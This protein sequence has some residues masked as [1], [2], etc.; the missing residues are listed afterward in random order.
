[1]TTTASGTATA[2]APTPGT[3]I[4]V[5]G[6]ENLYQMAT[7]QFQRAAE[8]VSLAPD[9]RTI[10]SQPKNEI[11]VNFPVRMDDGTFALFKGYRIQHNNILGCY[12]GGI[13]YHPQ[14]HLDEVKALAAWMTWKCSLAGLPF[15][16]GK[17][18]IQLDPSAYSDGELQR[19]TRRF[20][21]ALGNN[22]GPDFDVP[23]PDVGTNS[24]TMAWMM[25]TYVNTFG[26]AQKNTAKH[27]VTGKSIAAGGSEG[28]DEATGRG[29][30]YTIAA[31]AREK[32]FD[33]KGATF[34]V[35]GF[36]NV[37]SFAARI[38]GSEYGSRLLAAQDHT[39][40]VHAAGGIDPDALAKWVQEKKGVAGFPGAEAVGRDDFWSIQADV[41]IPAALEAQITSRNAPKIQT[42]LIAEGANGPTTPAAD[43][44]FRER[45]IDVIPDILCNS[46][47]VIVSYFE[48]TQNRQGENWYLDEV[49]GKLKRRITD[50][51]DR[52]AATMKRLRTDSRN[53]AMAVALERVAQAYR[54]RGIFP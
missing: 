54:E 35:Q 42:R 6:F 15:G 32:G 52:V 36:G 37:G 50:A 40:T 28:R 9:L 27:V 44:I 26:A 43:R 19:I 30:V 14:V 5:E 53:A 11:I 49:R 18:G 23:A 45:G 39:G 22:I 7:S 33:L 31:W 8:T 13:R 47:G 38:L 2:P 3:R 4:E 10:L 21:H 46:G 24:Q 41:V 12:K 20:T 1:V 34:T 51:Y 48:W 17:G 16:G 25:D 29:V